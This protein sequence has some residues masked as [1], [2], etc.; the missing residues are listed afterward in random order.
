[1]KWNKNYIFLALL[2]PVQM[3]LMHLA[4]NNPAVI[5]KYYSNGM[6]PYIS[7]LLRRLFGWI[8]YSVG[9]VFLAIFVLLF[10]RSLYLLIKTKFKNFLI[11]TTNFVAFLSILYFCFYLFWGLNYYREPLAKNLGYQQKKY[12]TEQLQKSTEYIISQLNNYHLKITKNDTIQ[13]K[14]PYSTEDLYKISL[15]GYKNLENDFP[16]LKYKVPSIKS[17]LMST[18]QSYNGT[19]GYLNPLTGEAQVNDRIS[20]TSFP[21]TACHEIAHQIGFAAENEANFVGFLAANY[22][23]DIY[24]KYASY[25]MAFGYSI[26]EIRK[27]NP[28]LSAQLWRTVNKGVIKDFNASYGFWQQYKN[29]F[30]PLLKKGYNA[31][32]KA[33][34]QAKGTDSYNYVVD[35]LISYLEDSK[36]I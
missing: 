30:E 29:P 33:N 11:K 17:S 22:N 5:E 27:R 28:E 34:K 3:L 10:L 2:L 16:Q 12:T 24:F 8:P 13:V 15:K 31:Y 36:Q 9:D 7:I 21:T 25:R 26:S 32:L 14:S 4:E 35:L 19:S 23:D 18:L 20:K 1:M 6:Y